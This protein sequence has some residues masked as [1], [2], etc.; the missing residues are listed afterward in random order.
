MSSRT[1]ALSLVM[2]IV[3]AYG[4]YTKV[5]SYRHIYVTFLLA[6]NCVCGV[7][8]SENNFSGTNSL[9]IAI[10]IISF[11]LQLTEIV[12]KSTNLAEEKTVCTP[13]NMK[14]FLPLMCFVTKQQ[15]VGGGQ[16]SR[17]DWTVL[18]IFSLTGAI[19]KLVL[20]I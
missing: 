8:A 3:I 16:Y 17:R 2:E 6:I 1:K 4:C 11:L 14:I 18:L 12:V 5:S 19:T 9:H 15:T 20:V 7:S 13:S 10:F